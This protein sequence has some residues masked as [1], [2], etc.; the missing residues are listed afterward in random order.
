MSIGS[1][2]QCG[3]KTEGTGEY[4]PPTC[5]ASECQQGSV[6][7]NFHKNVKRASALVLCPAGEGC[8]LLPATVDPRPREA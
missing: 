8:K 6:C 1:C 7:D 3:K 2:T 4:V 5:G